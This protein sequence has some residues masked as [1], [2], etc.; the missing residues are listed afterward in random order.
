MYITDFAVSGLDPLKHAYELEKFL[1]IA[2]S[3]DAVAGISLGDLWD[4]GTEGGAGIYTASKQPKPAAAK[5]DQLWKEEWTTRISEDM[6]SAGTLEFDGFF[7]TYQYELRSGDR[8]CAG[9]IDL[10]EPE[11]G[12][13]R[14][15]W[16][17]HNPSQ[18]F[19]VRCE[20]KGHVHI[21]VWATPA[22]IAFIMVGCLLGC[23]RKSK[24]SM[25]A[26][27]EAK[28]AGIEMGGAPMR[29]H[30]GGGQ[31]VRTIVST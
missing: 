11:G 2:F 18:R 22:I 12:V 19:S 31:R 29:S 24:E 16:R 23:W 30:R 15:T 9:E 28:R 25:A 13:L 27:A 6:N 4:K 5:L 7:G 20:W 17:P 1:R 26:K 21:P 10:L 8:V 3:H 14:D